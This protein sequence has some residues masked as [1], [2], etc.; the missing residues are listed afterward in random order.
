MLAVV[1]LQCVI[2]LYFNHT[3]VKRH[4]LF[5]LS[6]CIRYT[7]EKLW[8]G[9]MWFSLRNEYLPLVSNGRA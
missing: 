8:L 6:V 9:A 3:I 1:S 5:V 2:H 7:C 4:T